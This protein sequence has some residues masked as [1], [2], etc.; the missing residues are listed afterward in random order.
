MSNHADHVANQIRENLIAI[1]EEAG[2]GDSAKI[3]SAAKQLDTVARERGSELEPRLA[4]FLERR[5][6][7]KAL[8]FLRREE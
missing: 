2:S 4:H 1:V 5:S 6:Y 3:I 7:Q 8:E